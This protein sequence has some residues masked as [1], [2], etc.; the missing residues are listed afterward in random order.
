MNYIENG[1]SNK[2]FFCSTE[3]PNVF[4]IGDSIRKGYCKTVKN[5]MA[6]VA[7][8]F[9]VDDNCRNTQYVITR[10]E[11][12][13]N[14]FDDPSSVNIVHFNC[15]HWD[16]ARWSGY[17]IPLTSEGEYAR[18]IKMVIDLIRVKFPNAKLIFAT[19]TCM[20]PDNLPCRNMRDNE[21][22]ARY[23]E[24]AVKVA[25]EN[26]VLI[27]DLNKLTRDFGSDCYKD[28]CHHTEEAAAVV[29]K[30]VADKLKALL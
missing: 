9:Y 25:E 29:G 22:I 17:E 30:A 2:E 20:N 21:I 16:V 4:L 6:D 5:E 19:T 7:E 26:D 27:N 13:K 12:W 8:V 28:S 24:I 1:L 10:L 14:M 23:N 18:N 15:G 11:M 3:K